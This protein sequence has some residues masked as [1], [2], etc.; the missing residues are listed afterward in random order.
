MS[1]YEEATATRL[2]SGAYGFVQT[3]T[4]SWDQKVRALPNA[5]I[6][7]IALTKVNS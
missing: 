6:R 5:N 7:F 3:I 2:A 1:K 4:R